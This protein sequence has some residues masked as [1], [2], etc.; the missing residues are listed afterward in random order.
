MLPLALKVEEGGR[1]DVAV[2]FMVVRWTWRGLK[3]RG[4]W[5]VVV[6]LERNEL[7]SGEEA[8]LDKYPSLLKE[9]RR[10]DFGLNS[11]C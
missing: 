1:G 7:N 3:S 9:E 4:D 5:A 6:G 11:A 2:H 10:S 8:M